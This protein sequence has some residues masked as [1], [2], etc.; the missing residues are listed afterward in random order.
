MRNR[1]I[2][3]FCFRALSRFFSTPRKNIF[4]ARKK[5]SLENFEM[6]Q[7]QKN[8]NGKSTFLVLKFVIFHWKFYD[9]GKIQNFRATFFFEME[10]YFFLELKKKSGQSFEAENPYLS[11]K[12]GPSSIGAIQQQR[13]RLECLNPLKLQLSRI[14]SG[15]ASYVNLD[16][17]LEMSIRG[18]RSIS[19]SVSSEILK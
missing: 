8:F 11:I 1:K 7:N 6:F 19:H 14:F 5:M 17:V 4:L 15:P 18:F 9:F 2:W 10:K 3:F 16:W 12:T 13:Q